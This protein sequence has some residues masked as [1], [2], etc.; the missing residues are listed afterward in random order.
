MFLFLYLFLVNCP[1]G[2]SCK[3][4]AN[5]AVVR[6]ESGRVESLSKRH[7]NGYIGTK[8]RGMLKLLGRRASLWTND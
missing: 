3:S 7:R 1:F 4:R 5:L 8:N 6:L 2:S